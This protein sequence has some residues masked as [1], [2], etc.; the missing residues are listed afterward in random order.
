M[1][2]V[3][4][5]DD[6]PVVRRHLRGLLERDACRVFEAQDGAEGLH[7]LTTHP[8]DVVFLD[9]QMPNV[10][11]FALLQQ[12]KEKKIAVPVVLITSSDNSGEIMRAVKLGAKDYLLKPF[13]EPQVRR[14]M[15]VAAGLDHTT[16]HRSRADVAVLD[17]DEGLAQT[18][19]TLVSERDVVEHVE[20]RKDVPDCVSRPHQLVLVGTYGA[21][22]RP[23]EAEE[24]EAIGDLVT[25]HDPNAVLLRL[26]P[27]EGD[28]LPEVTVFHAAVVRTDEVR[29]TATELRTASATHS[30]FRLRCLAM[31]ST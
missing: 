13:R 3:L 16:I 26:L 24:A 7:A 21:P 14:A 9:L 17:Q 2:T 28:A 1:K 30:T 20:Q 15:Q 29:L 22:G 25:Q 5:V 18:V 23:T 19:R 27:R 11:G 31:L 4:V 12:L 8:F 6:N 10:D